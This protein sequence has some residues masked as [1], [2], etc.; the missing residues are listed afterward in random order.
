MGD[1]GRRKRRRL[2]MASVPQASRLT[3]LRAFA[4]GEFVII[5]LLAIGWQNDLGWSSLSIGTGTE[6]LGAL[7]TGLLILVTMHFAA[8]EKQA[9]DEA[10]AQLRDERSREAAENVLMWPALQRSSQTGEPVAW[11][12]ALQNYSNIAVVEWK[13]TVRSNRGVPTAEYSSAR[14]GGLT[15]RASQPL[16]L[17]L[18]THFSPMEPP[19]FASQLVWRDS[20]GWRWVL[21]EFTLRRVEDR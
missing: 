8:T 12:V 17:P 16:L 5:V 20:R 21:D 14:H 1:A 13:L 19:D 9:R 3:Y 6:L 10:T 2:A 15:P 18:T 11:C 4:F 7:L